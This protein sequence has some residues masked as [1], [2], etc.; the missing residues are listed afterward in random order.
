VLIGSPIGI[1]E[2]ID[3]LTGTGELMYSPMGEPTD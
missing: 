3:E 2:P 1:G